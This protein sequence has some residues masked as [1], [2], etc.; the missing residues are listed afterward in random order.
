MALA[1]CQ[2]ALTRPLRSSLPIGAKLGIAGFE[3]VAAGELAPPTLTQSARREIRHL[4]ASNQLA[5][6]A[7]EVPMHVGLDV[8]EQQEARIDYLRQAMT[9]AFDLG[10][11]SVIIQPG[12]IPKDDK[13]PRFALLSDALLALGQ[14]GDRVG[15]TLALET[16]IDPADVL[17]TFLGRLD[18]GS[19]ALAFNPGILLVHGQEPYRFARA[20]RARIVCVH[21]TDARRGL[22]PRLVPVGRGDVDW[23]EM[24]AVFAEIEYQG[25]LTIDVEPGPNAATEA[26]ASAAFLKRLMM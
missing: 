19:L 12:P 26:A 16:G 20:L 2:K 24:M 21:A 9:L 17:E 15:A 4:F 23:L 10:C 25:F 18:T 14:H 6:A 3:L 13:D 22:S 5:I 7:L 8:P 1:L 11:R